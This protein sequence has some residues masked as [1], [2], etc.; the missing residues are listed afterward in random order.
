MKKIVIICAVFLAVAAALPFLPVNGEQKIYSDTVRLHVVANSDTDADQ[1][2]KLK[3]RDAVLGEVAALVEDAGDASEAKERIGGALDAIGAA[4][5]RAVTE[6]GYGYDVAVTF[7]RE[8][9]PQRSYGELRLPAGKY[10]SLRV[11]V[12]A[13]EGR[14]WWCVL[15]PPLCTSAAEPKEELAQAG[16]TGETIRI[17]TEDENPKY[18]LRFRILEFFESLFS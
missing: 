16:F 12:G 15:F 2:L 3:V 18:V 14:N 8:L 9:Y 17:L 6:N 11:T 5:K 1:E 13:G 4:A 7:D 10:T